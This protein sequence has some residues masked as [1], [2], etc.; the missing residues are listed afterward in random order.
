MATRSI[1]EVPALTTP[2]MQHPYLAFVP[3]PSSPLTSP[4]ISFD[5]TP[6]HVPVPFSLDILSDRQSRRRPTW[7]DSSCLDTGVIDDRV[8]PP[9]N[10]SRRTISRFSPR[11]PSSLSFQIRADSITDGKKSG[12]RRAVSE[13]MIDHDGLA[14]GTYGLERA[15]ISARTNR[16]GVL[17]ESV[18]VIGLDDEP[19]EDFDVEPRP[20]FTMARP[21]SP[22]PALLDDEESDEDEGSEDSVPGPSDKSTF[23][24]F[25]RPIFTVKRRRSGRGLRVIRAPG[26][27]LCH[28]PRIC[29]II[30]CIVA[31]SRSTSWG[32]LRTKIFRTRSSSVPPT[33]QDMVQKPVTPEEYHAYFLNLYMHRE[34]E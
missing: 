31:R 13:G 7:R 26:K 12:H 3:R 23:F 30:T 24:C 2:L 4:P 21:A 18:E 34:S 32:R 15:A 10:V 1:N 27:C 22:V 20:P 19:P 14:R 16:N 5:D 25:G 11:R 33:L 28:S 6:A 9:F 29:L 8:P 17:P